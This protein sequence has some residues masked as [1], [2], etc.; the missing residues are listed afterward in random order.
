[1]PPDSNSGKGV[2]VRLVLSALTSERKQ[3][4]KA[5]A[6]TDSLINKSFI[7]EK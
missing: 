4:T 1:M 2:N 5:V 6:R 3:M 7:I